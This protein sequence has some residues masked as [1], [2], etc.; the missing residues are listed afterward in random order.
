MTEEE[1]SKGAM[2]PGVIAGGHRTLTSPGSLCLGVAGLLLCV[3]VIV[4]A[5][6]GADDACSQGKP[7]FM[8]ATNA[9]LDSDIFSREYGVNLTACAEACRRDARCRSLT[10][11]KNATDSYCQLMG[12]AADASAVVHERT[13]SP[14]NGVYY[15]E[16]ICLQGAC[17][18][19]FVAE[20][21][22]G[23]ELEGH[24][25]RVLGNAT[26]RACLEACAA[27]RSFVCRS[28]E[29]DEQRGGEC[30]L[31]RYDRFSRHVHFGRSANP[32]VAYF[33][34]TSSLSR[35]QHVNGNCS[36]RVHGRDSGEERENRGARRS[37]LINHPRWDSA[38]TL[39]GA[40]GGL[41]DGFGKMSG[42]HTAE[43]LLLGNVEHPYSLVEYRGLSVS[44][45]GESCLRNALFPCR[46]FLFGR[47]SQQQTYCGLTHQ[48]R[49]GLLQNPGSFEPSHS[50]NYY[51]IARN[52]DACDDEDVK[53]ELVSGR[54][55]TDRPLRTSQVS[56]AHE[57]LALCR[58]DAKCRSVSYD[59][60]RRMCYAHSDTLRTGIDTNV[61]RNPQMNYFEKVC[62]SAGSVCDK[63]WAFERVPG[64]ELVVGGSSG[65]QSKVSVEANTREECQAACLAHRDFVCHSAEFNYQL[66]E[67][68][69][70]PHSRFTGAS[71]EPKLEDSKFVVD[72]FEN[73]CVREVRG[74]CS[75]KKYRDQE[76]VLAD[77]VIGTMSQE[78]CLQRCL[79]SID[80][81]CRSFSFERDTQTC[82][83]SHHTRKSAPK[84][85]TLR[86]PGTDLVELGACFDVSV[87]CEPHVMRARVRSNMVFKGKVYTRGRPSTC[88]QDISSSMDFTLPIQ[89][90]GSDCGT[91]SK[92]EGHFAN[93]LVIQSNDQVVTAMDKAIGVSCTFDVG[94]KTEFA[95]AKVSDPRQTDHSRGKPPL[96]ELSLHIL[97]MRGNERESVSLGELVRVQVRMSEEDTYGIFIKNLIARDGTGSTNLTLIDKTG[98]PV[99]AKMMREI[100]TIDSHSKS[101]ESYLEAFAF[102][103]SSTLELEAEVV[104]CLERCKPVS[105]Q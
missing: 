41:M 59:Y 87:E 15:L 103:G 62:I 19:L 69:L 101:L 46:S 52:L 26:R 12:A 99:E 13:L 73:N 88:S 97:D 58:G 68:R 29:W 17:D 28:A 105:H 24:D 18:R 44:E 98:C 27:E 83:L 75:T 6:P 36:E 104:T 30:R 14:V 49:A 34:N 65:S 57:C 38:Q 67:C 54:Y 21:I 89:L 7:V 5:V 33:D 93:V 72:Y 91:V 42:G 55:M 96:P 47:R 53:F 50:L 76:L 2:T 90:A 23:M 94:N 85:A 3:P 82:F 8:L 71:G 31:S 45:C 39:D 66:S 10:F 102:T 43:I 22:Q 32:S 9:R 95:S 100:R 84:G 81:V 1:R 11:V 61:K 48:N 92:A 80:F 51:E 64:K 86:L 70:S 20:W 56:S 16:K 35:G 77:L 4:G 37:Q 79:N 25:N 63:H 60:R 78:D 74:F 40:E